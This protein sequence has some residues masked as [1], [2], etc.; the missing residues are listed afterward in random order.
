M[1]ILHNFIFLYILAVVFTSC[2]NTSK[3][4]DIHELSVNGDFGIGA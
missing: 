4:E 1:K 2:D 3:D